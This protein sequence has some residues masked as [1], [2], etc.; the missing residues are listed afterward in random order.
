M[1]IITPIYDARGIKTGESVQYSPGESVLG[2]TPSY[3]PPTPSVPSA[4]PAITPQTSYT[5]EQVAR[6]N[7]MRE[8]AVNAGQDPYAASSAYITSIKSQNIIPRPEPNY[9]SPK[10]IPIELIPDYSTFAIP[11]SS[12]ETRYNVLSSRLENVQRELLGR[13]AFEAEMR[14][15]QGVDESQ[16]MIDDLSQRLRD[17]KREEQAI[18]LK[19]QE[20]FTGRGA[21]AGGVAP[22]ETGR[23][24][25]NAIEGLTA[26]ALIDAASNRMLSAQRKVEAAVQ[27]KY[28]PLLAEQT[29]LLQN[30]D[31][32][33]KSPQLSREEKEQAAYQQYIVQKRK[34]ETTKQAAETEEIW[35]IATTAAQNTANFKPTAQYPTASTALTAMQK[36]A[37][38]EKALQ[39]AMETGLT[40]KGTDW[41][42]FTDQEKRKLTQA[43]L[44]KAP[45]QKQLDYLYEGEKETIYNEK[46]I[47]PV[48]R[49]DIID[50]LTDKKGAKVMGKELTLLD[51]IKLFPNVDKQTLEDYMD[52]FYDYEEL[53]KEEETTGKSWW[54]FWK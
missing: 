5:P 47:T 45:F 39:I 9:V 30:L 20:E 7:A 50:T 54:Q 26:S 32:L 43:G 23:L 35:K 2:A 33:V 31:I 53:I 13:S 22:I 1:P 36:A 10:K 19:I 15:S 18:P 40:V 49:Q 6:I 51:M 14:K 12:S 41:Q 3:T 52:K 44:Q 25:R 42:Q 24:R 28:G 11:P 34:D 48:L 21:T 37:T 27:Q 46:T 29:S 16:Q 8:Q 4:P 38:K 17:L